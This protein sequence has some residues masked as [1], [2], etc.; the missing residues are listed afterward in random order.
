MQEWVSKLQKLFAGKFDQWVCHF[1]FNFFI[2]MS[3]I[4][5]FCL[6]AHPNFATDENPAEATGTLILQPIEL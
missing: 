6:P 3:R 4:I 1:R 5:R 2:T